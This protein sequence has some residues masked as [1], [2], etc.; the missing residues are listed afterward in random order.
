MGRKERARLRFRA[1]IDATQNPPDH[2]K[3]ALAG[4]GARVVGVFV[5]VRG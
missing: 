5:D 4:A 2:S 3:E 1:L